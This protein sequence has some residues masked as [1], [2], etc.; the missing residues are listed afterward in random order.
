MRS[1]HP[2]AVGFHQQSQQKDPSATKENEK[3]QWGNLTKLFP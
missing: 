1:I 2:A 3:R